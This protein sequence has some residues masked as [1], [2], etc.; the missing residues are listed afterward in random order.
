MAGLILPHDSCGSHLDENGRTTDHDLERQNFE[1]AG[2]ILAEVWSNTTIDSHPVYAVFVSNE[3]VNPPKLGDEWISK[4]VL[5]S[6]YT[7]QIIKCH[8]SCCKLVYTAKAFLTC[9][10]KPMATHPLT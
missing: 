6:Q 2:Q 1:K 4:H 9:T 7:L 8:D 10:C 5:Q 3:S